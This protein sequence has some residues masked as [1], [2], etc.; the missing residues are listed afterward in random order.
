MRIATI[1]FGLLVSTG[2]ALAQAPAAAPN[3]LDKD[4]P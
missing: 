4:L 1:A 2:A 3:P